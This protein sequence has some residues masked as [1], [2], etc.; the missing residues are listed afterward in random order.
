MRRRDFLIGSIAAAS[1][2]CVGA[3]A[4]PDMAKLD[5][6]GAMSG[7]FDN[8]LAETRDWSQSVTPKELDILDF[9][10][11]LADH[12]GIHNV[13][14]QQFHFL[15]MEP[16]YFEKFLGRLQKAKSRM[17]DMP[18]ELDTNGYRGTITP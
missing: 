13:E 12:Y 17:I 9:P 2:A 5:R 18:L 7:D 10:Q 1:T 4:V 11:M 14:V 6:V 8:I 3:H 16:S 15:S